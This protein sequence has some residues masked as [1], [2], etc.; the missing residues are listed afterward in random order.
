MLTKRLQDIN[1]NDV[2]EFLLEVQMGNIAGASIINRLG[3]NPDVDSGAEE[4]VWELGGA[5]SEL[6]EATTLY[7]WSTEEDT[8]DILITGVDGDYTKVENYI[9]TLTGTT[10][11][12]VSQQFLAVCEM[13][14]DNGTPLAGTVY[15]SRVS[16]STTATN[17]VAVITP[18]HERSLLGRCIIPAGYHGYIFLGEANANVVNIVN[19]AN[20]VVSFYAKKLGK[21]YQLV[22]EVQADGVPHSRPW[23]S[24]PEKTAVKTTSTSYDTN[25]VVRISFYILLLD[26]TIWEV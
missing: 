25:N 15:L 17:V 4:D 5:Y 7:I 9:V 20:A 13:S 14:N 8:V 22:D 21:V 10:P 12:E 18:P 19:V 26:K 2:N 23:I 6:T 24:I 1:G 16:G 3:K 11:V